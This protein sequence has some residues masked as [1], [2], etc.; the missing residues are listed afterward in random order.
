MNRPP[1][2]RRARSVTE[3]LLSIVL[4][5]EACVLFFAGLV[6]FGLKVVEPVLPAWAALAGAGAFIVLLV[7]TTAVLR[8]RWGVV[9][10]WVWQ[11]ALIACGILMP[12][13]YAI[14]VGFAL[15]WIWCFNRG[16]RI[17]AART[18]G[19]ANRPATDPDPSNEGE[20]P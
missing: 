6:A 7:A 16:R 9:I 20:T 18:S 10:G 14:G 8:Y 5:L 12:L 17:D 15:L 4:V 3:S 1:G 19:A 11:A 13:M 2:T